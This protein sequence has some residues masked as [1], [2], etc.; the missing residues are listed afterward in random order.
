LPALRLLAVLLLVGFNAFFAAVEF[1]LVAVRSSRIRQLAEE[2]DARARIVQQLLGEM[3]RVVSGVQVGVTFASLSLGFIGEATIA[4]LIERLVVGA[5]SPQQLFLIHGFSLALAFLSLTF[6]HVVLGEL[7]PKT[8]SLERAE[9]VALLVARPFS[10]FLHT[11]GFTI[12][13]LEGSATRIN[14]ALGAS[15]GHSRPLVHSAEELQILVQQAR[16][17]GLFEPGEEKFIQRA[18]ELGEIQV[19]EIMVPRRDVHA[20]PVDTAL[21]DVLRMLAVT[22]RSRLPVYEGSLDHPIGYIHVKDILWVLLDRERRQEEGAPLPAFHLRAEVRPIVIVPETKAAGE[23]LRELRSKHT[24]LAMVVDEFGTILGLVTLED[25]L[26]QIVGEI[27]DEFD[28]V[29]RPLTL[30]DGAMVV[31]GSLKMRDLETQ[32]GIELPEDPSYETLGGFVMA[33]LGFIPKG[34]ESFEMAGLRFTV[35]EVE[36]RRVARVK[37]QRLRTPV[38][39]PPDDSQSVANPDRRT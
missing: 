12:R 5:A 8:I 22:Q 11:F 30:P 31:D 32:Y 17:Q 27:Y 1:S 38:S 39:A 21:D 14:R 29:E 10:L 6:L 36:R 24:G 16:E 23:L 13:V 2:G 18:I 4:S 15:G 20:L 34:G 37:V 3:S 19:R 35:T 7:V 33:R 9:Q 25:L 28:V 26:E